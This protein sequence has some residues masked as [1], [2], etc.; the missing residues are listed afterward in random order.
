MSSPRILHKLLAALD[1]TGVTLVGLSLGTG[2]LARYIGKYG[3][4]RLARCVFIREP[5]S[6]VH[7]VEREPA[8][9]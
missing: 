4:E 7:E 1:L 6:L 3:S 9:S 2:Q 5:R 8:G